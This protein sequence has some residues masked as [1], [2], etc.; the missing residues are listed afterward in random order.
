MRDLV[1]YVATSIDGFIADVDGDFSAFPQDPATLAALF[2]RYPETCPTHARTALGVSGQS[3]RFDTVIMGYRTYEPALAAGLPGGAYPH[4]RQIIATHRSVPDTPN[5]A[6]ISGDLPAHIA[7]L[8]GQ[9]GRDIWLCGGA[10]LAAQLIDH[11]DEFQIKVNPVVLGS[12]IPLVSMSGPSVGF[13]LTGSE[14]LP[15]GVALLTYRAR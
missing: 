10:D 4:L 15:G 11:I 9:P 12:G 6:A 8:K 5:L 7:R 13:R 2:D 3:R 1:Y 14:L